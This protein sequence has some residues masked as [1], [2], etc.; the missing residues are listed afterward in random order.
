MVKAKHAKTELLSV[1][2]VLSRIKTEKVSAAV[3]VGVQPSL[4]EYAEQVAGKRERS[5]WF[6]NQV[7]ENLR[8]KREEAEEKKA[9]ETWE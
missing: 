7:L 9:A 5:T 2:E 6:R 1:D 3:T 8:R 4:L